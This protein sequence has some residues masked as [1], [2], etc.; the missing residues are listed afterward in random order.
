M[1]ILPLHGQWPC[2]TH[3]RENLVSSTNFAWH[4]HPNFEFNFYTLDL[5]LRGSH[6]ELES[7]T[8]ALH[9][10]HLCVWLFRNFATKFSPLLKLNF[11]VRILGPKISLK[12]KNLQSNSRRQRASQSL[13]AYLLWVRSISVALLS[14]FR[15]KLLA[16]AWM[17]TNSELRKTRTALLQNSINSNFLKF[18]FKRFSRMKI[19]KLFFCSIRTI[20]VQEHLLIT[21]KWSDE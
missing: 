13:M 1:Q 4:V 8:K 16:W 18:S 20:H 19:Q 21:K 10:E 17:P 9:L 5:T 12:A 11:E 6:Y 3:G 7:F 2:W 15:E 14:L